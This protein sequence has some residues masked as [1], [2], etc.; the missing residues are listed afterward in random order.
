MVVK[1][2][3]TDANKV[4]RRL[5]GE[6]GGRS[7]HSPGRTL[8]IFFFN[9]KYFFFVEIPSWSPCK[10]ESV[11]AK[12]FLTGVT[13]INSYLAIKAEDTPVQNQPQSKPV[14]HH[15]QPPRNFVQI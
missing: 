3:Y 2:R 7:F 15:Q 9:S 14:Q 5:W 13:E 6:A 1:T 10:G 12:V 11:Y 8:T 4:K